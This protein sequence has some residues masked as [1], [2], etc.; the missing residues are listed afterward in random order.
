MSTKITDLTQLVGTPADSDVVLI[1]DVSEDL[2]SK[3]LFR[4]SFLALHQLVLL[5]SIAQQSTLLAM[6]LLL[7]IQMFHLLATLLSHLC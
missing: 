3:L 2:L 6:L 1:T 5:F 7:S 4:T